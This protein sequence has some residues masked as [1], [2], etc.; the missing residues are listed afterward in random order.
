M[1]QIVLAIF[2]CVAAAAPAYEDNSVEHPA[3]LVD[4]R[5]MA[6]D[7]SS[8]TFKI[9]TQDGISRQESG[10]ALPGTASEEGGIEQ[11]GTVS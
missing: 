2:A 4:E 8:Y 1:L 3:I 11:S 9:E 7:A 10:A 6:D 5:H